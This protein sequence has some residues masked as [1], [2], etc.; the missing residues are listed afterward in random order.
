MFAFTAES[1][2]RV[3]LDNTPN[4]T[5]ENKYNLYSNQN[6]EKHVTNSHLN[7]IQSKSILSQTFFSTENRWL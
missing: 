7:S 3:S 5:S 6:T 4:I 1:N 2:G